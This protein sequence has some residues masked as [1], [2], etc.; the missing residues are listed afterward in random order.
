[1]SYLTGGLGRKSAGSFITEGLSS[2]SQFQAAFYGFLDVVVNKIE[3][4]RLQCKLL[5]N[6]ETAT[7][8]RDVEMVCKLLTTLE[9]E[10]NPINLT[11]KTKKVI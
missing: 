9:T 5:T 4:P 11:T 1:M 2:L 7:N 10:S 3:N 6:L 8:L